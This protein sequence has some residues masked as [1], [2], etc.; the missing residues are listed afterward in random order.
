[1]HKVR[2]HIPNDKAFIF[3]ELGA[4]SK[5]GMSG[6]PKDMVIFSED[7]QALVYK[8]QIELFE[9]QKGIVG[10]SPWILKDFR[11]TLRMRQGIQ[12]YWNLKGLIDDNGNRKKAFHVLKEFYGEN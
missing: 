12:D 7:Y 6:D 1:M 4:G 11:S 9:N 8:K 2:F 3:S 10:M 5:R